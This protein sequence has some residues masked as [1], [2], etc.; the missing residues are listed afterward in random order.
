MNLIKIT[1]MWYTLMCIPLIF[2]M[3]CSSDDDPVIKPISSFQFEIDATDF[4]KVNFSNF[5]QNATSYAWDFGDAVGTSTDE[6]PSYIYSASGTYTVTLTASDATTSVSSSKDITIT[7]P[8][9]ALTLLAGSVSKTWKLVRTGASLGVG[10][11]E[12]EWT[13]W[14]AAVNDGSRNC[15][16]DDEVIFTRDGGFEFNDNGTMF[17]E[18]NVYTGTDKASLTEKCFDATVA[19]MTVDGV[20]KSAWLSST[21]HTYAYNV[22]TNKITLTGLGAWIGT[23]KLATSGEVA[24]PQ[25]SVEFGVKLASGGD[26]GVDTLNVLFDYSGVFWK[27]IYV[28]YSNPS[29]EP[30]L[31]AIFAD[32]SVSTSSFDATFTNKSSGA[33]TYAWDFG[34]GESSTEENPVHTYAADGT[35]SVT[36][37]ATDGSDTDTVTK[38]VIIDTANPADAAPAPAQ[39]EADVIS[40]YSDT[41]TSLAGVDT[42]P[43]WGQATVVTEQEVVVGDNILKLAGLNYQGIDFGGAQD[44]TGKTMVHIDIW[45]KNVI[46]ANLS[47]ISNGAETPVALTTEAGVWKSFDIP[48]SDYS[49]VVDITAVIQ[50]KFDAATSVTFFVDNI[51]FY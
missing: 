18:G 49:S 37:T 14:F 11:S 9:E 30:A 19:N 5:S 35:Y 28:S 31:V 4:F 1:K 40:I 21:S 2:I 22:A 47:L 39:A 43:D 12:A 33:T 10:P 41:Y 7:D 38:D 25:A 15:I 45:A 8:D 44:L 17:G 34:D 16:Y 36:L 42:N 46:T 51:Y 13:S 50:F 23:Y 3:S 24:V 32:F 48:L 29:D 20:D 27:A 26:S 6:S